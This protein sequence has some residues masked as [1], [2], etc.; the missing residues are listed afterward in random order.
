MRA[1]T[2][3]Q[4]KAAQDYL[5]MCRTELAPLDIEITGTTIW[6]VDAILLDPDIDHDLSI[7]LRPFENVV[8]ESESF[9]VVVY[10]HSE[11]IACVCARAVIA[12]EDF[13]GEWITNSRLFGCFVPR[14]ENWPDFEYVEEPPILSGVIGYG[15]G[16]WVRPDFRS[17]KFWAVTSRIGKILALT[18]LDV[19]YYVA[20]MK[21]SR[22]QTARQ[23]LGWSNTVHLTRGDHPG[24]E[25]WQSDIDMHWMNRSELLAVIDDP[26]PVQAVGKSLSDA[27]AR[28]RAFS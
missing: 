21:H 26:A 5:E 10:H 11:P 9:G 13:V 15:G 28:Q 18:H 22:T 7:G 25:N 3:K 14:F 8:Q 27:R 2:H 17:H 4:Q 24:R 19:D 20:L 1:L 6:D 12:H 23:T 16:S